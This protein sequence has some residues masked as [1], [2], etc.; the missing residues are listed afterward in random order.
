MF[1]NY[2]YTYIRLDVS[3]SE[4]FNILL[5]QLAS[6]A[7]FSLWAEGVV[8]WETMEAD[9][10]W[11]RGFCSPVGGMTLSGTLLGT[12]DSCSTS[13]AGVLVCN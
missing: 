11:L 6:P 5:S 7:R 13:V 2:F 9:M 12:R 3:A 10:H 8:P 4:L 1:C